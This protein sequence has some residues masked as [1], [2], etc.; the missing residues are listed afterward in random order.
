[1]LFFGTWL[2]VNLITILEK[3]GTD[4]STAIRALHELLP[5]LIEPVVRV[6]VLSELV[7]HSDFS[8]K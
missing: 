2:R 1:M 7:M 8:Q 4:K 5:L 3:D 6:L